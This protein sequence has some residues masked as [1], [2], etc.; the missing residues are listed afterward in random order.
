MC[1][2]GSSGGEGAALAPADD[3]R[4]ASSVLIAAQDVCYTSGVLLKALDGYASPEPF[5]AHGGQATPE[6][7]DASDLHQKVA[8]DPDTQAILEANAVTS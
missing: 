6:L 8:F 5:D 7:I 1:K 2:Q 3:V 4:R